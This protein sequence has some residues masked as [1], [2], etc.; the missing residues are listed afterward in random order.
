MSLDAHLVRPGREHEPLAGERL[1]QRP[2]AARGVLGHRVARQVELAVAPAGAHE[3]RPRPRAP[4]DRA[5]RSAARGR[6]CRRVGLLL[7]GGHGSGV[8]CSLTPPPYDAIGSPRRPPIGSSHAQSPPRERRLHGRGDRGGAA[9]RAAGA[10]RRRAVRRARLAGARHRRSRRCRWAAGGLL[11][12]A[13]PLRAGAQEAARVG[14][15]VG[16]L[17]GDRGGA[18]GAG[19]RRL[20]GRLR[21]PGEPLDRR[22]GHRGGQQGALPAAPAV[23]APRRAGRHPRRHRLRRHG[24]RRLRLRGEHPLP[25]RGVQRHRRRG[26]GWDVG[27]DQHLRAALPVQPVRAPAVHHLHRHRGR[28][29]GRLP[30]APRAPRGAAG[31]VPASPSPRTPPGTPRPSTASTASSA[32]TCC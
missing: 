9:R 14:A 13:G 18:A 4:W 6:G 27:A 26:P 24:R 12:V 10:A 1:G 8:V 20:R 5:T 16:R 15:A 30:Q 31:R 3:A 2:P 25:R 7:G 22:A 23:V 21:R 29:R 19:H 17:R 11:P 32:S 28:H